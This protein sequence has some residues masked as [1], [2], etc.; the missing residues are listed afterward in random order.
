MAAHALIATLPPSFPVYA[1][2]AANHDRLEPMERLR[3]SLRAHPNVGFFLFLAGLWAGMAGVYQGFVWLS[4]DAPGGLP[5]LVVWGGLN[6]GLFALL[7]YGR[8]D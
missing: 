5:F 7:S 8:R 6:L 4:T 1:A 3:A 2:I